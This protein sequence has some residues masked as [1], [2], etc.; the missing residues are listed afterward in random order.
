MTGSATWE[1]LAGRDEQRARLTSF[2]ESGDRSRSALALSGRLGSGKT[3]LLEA[4]L[5]SARS[6]GYR[7]LTA[8]GA[9]VEAGIGLATLN[10]V[11]WPERDAMSARDRRNYAALAGAFGQGPATAVDPER[12][13]DAALA[14]LDRPGVHS[15][16]LIAVD[17]MQWAD[18]LSAAVLAA[19]ARAASGRR[20][21]VLVAY[22]A[23]EPAV[24]DVSGF[25]VVQVP[26]LDVRAASTLLERLAPSLA[27]SVHARLLHEA[28]GNPL[29]L[30]EL[31]D[32]LTPAQRRAQQA[33]PPVLPLSRRLRAMF[34][35]RVLELDEAVR[36]LLVLIALDDGGRLYRIAAAR[37][38]STAE[39]LASPELRRAVSAGLINLTDGAEPGVIFDHPLLRPA[40]V[41]MS[42]M[43]WRRRANRDLARAYADDAARSVPHLAAAAEGYDGPVAHRLAERGYACLDRGDAVSAVAALVQAAELSPDSIDRNRRFAH[44]AH[45]CV[46]VIGDLGQASTLLA[47][48]HCAAPTTQRTPHEMVAAARLC[49][50][51]EGDVDTAHRLLMATLRA[52]SLEDHPDRRTVAFTLR[53][54]VEVCKYAGRPELWPPLR[55]AAAAFGD[56]VPTDV[57]LLLAVLGHTAQATPAAADNVAAALARLNNAEAHE[58]TAVDRTATLAVLV[59]RVEEFSVAVRQLV[60]GGPVHGPVTSAVNAAT[61]LSL[62]EFHRGNWKR[63]GHLIDDALELCR[64]HGLTLPEVALRYGRALLA[65]VS[66][67]TES[68]ERLTTGITAWAAPRRVCTGQR[69]VE[70]AR[71]VSALGLG[72][73]AEA[74]RLL[75]MIGR[76]TATPHNAPYTLWMVYDVVEAAARSGHRDEALAYVQ[77][78]RRLEV[79]ALSS[80]L[81]VAV[82]GAAALT[83]PPSL[84]GLLFEEALTAPGGSQWRFDHARVRLSYGEHLRR[85]RRIIHA[86]TQL[87]LALADF[88]ELGAWPWVA[89][90]SIELRAA[91][92]SAAPAGD[93]DRILTPQQHEIAALAGS[94]LTNKQIAERLQLSPRTVAAHLRQVFTKLGA[95]TRGALHDAMHMADPSAV[96]PGP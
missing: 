10:Q 78:V 95:N 8:S 39:L 68:V 60:D 73:F 5:A 14:A 64:E 86:R 91:G 3:A 63:S 16:V 67:D 9:K 13:A 76:A 52:M 94:G 61:V 28:Q 34:T 53:G 36:R 1:T 74:H 49:L 80:R 77:A 27:P 4:T 89:R 7:V 32:V 85:Q 30:V 43:D 92:L 20:L 81:A 50:L 35:S 40:L 26:S 69:L 33:I 47:E 59:D 87:G 42:D 46:D 15:P 93:S 48:A 24:L 62:D 21:A 22:R 19:L 31:A 44:A 23:D 54:L 25:D 58:P 38:Q 51:S 66:G 11:L 29:A 65:A 45:L 82:T 75:E 2:L 57:R 70:H 72:R 71:A 96:R 84:A 79:A 55:A 17:D 12:F 56:V 83:A 41:A 90:A 6:A 88:R 37:G 18:G